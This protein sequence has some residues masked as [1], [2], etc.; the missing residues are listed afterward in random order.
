MGLR[1]TVDV[2]KSTKTN[3]L[4]WNRTNLTTKKIDLNVEKHGKLCAQFTL[5]L[6][7]P[8]ACWMNESF[9]FF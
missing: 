4:L 8:F 6:F 2:T 5:Q 7:N 1:V 9:V 3:N